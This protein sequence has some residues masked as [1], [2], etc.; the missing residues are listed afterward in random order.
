MIRHHQ[1]CL[2]AEYENMLRVDGDNAILWAR[3]VLSDSSTVIIL[4]TET[5]GL[6]LSAEI[7][8]ISL[9][10]IDGA[11]LFDSLVKPTQPIPPEA[12]A[13]HHITDLD[14]AQ[15]PSFN[16]IYDRLKALLEGK[17]VV[18]YDA[19][20]DIQMLRQSGRH[21]HLPA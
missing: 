2:R 18:T 5:T 12:T 15:A 3:G 16:M 6:D 19:D 14:V 21:Y 13:I 10:T 4:D 20:F 8:Q 1:E 7:V 9:I 11:S 17:R